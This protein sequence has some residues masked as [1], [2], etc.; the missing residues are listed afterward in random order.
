MKDYKKE[1]KKHKFIVFCEDH[2][3]PLGV[4]RSLGE[5]DIRP[6]VILI[7]NG[8][9][10]KLI[11]K[12]KYPLVIH[13]VNTKEDGLEILI[14]N[15][16]KNNG[17]KPFVYSCSD[18]VC[19][20]IDK[21]YDI[22]KND[23]FVFHGREQ[24]IVSQ[25][26][27]KYAINDIAVKYG[28]S[29]LENEVLSKGEIPRKIEYPVLTKALTSTIYAWKDEMHICNNAEELMNAYKQIRSDK[30]LV[31][32]FINKKNEFCVDGFCFNDGKDV[33]IPYYS[34]YKRFTDLSY[35]AYMEFKPFDDKVIYD[36]IC[37]ILKEIGF[38]GIF[39]V[40]FLIDNDDNKWFLE[41]NFRNSTWSYAYTYGG[42]NMP[43][44]W[45]MGTLFGKIDID[46]IC[47][48]KNFTAIAEYEDYEMA[49]KY[50]TMTLD[51]W[52]KEFKLADVHYFYNEQDKKPF[53]INRF[54]IKKRIKKI[55]GKK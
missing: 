33:I 50:G 43:Y 1:L 42:Y 21:H 40:E 24:G 46:E 45:A 14:S 22:L 31:Q 29:V 36:Q 16:G 34:S 4:V 20:L 3:N 18:N 35:G 9:T 54:I 39:E 23:F 53:S 37:S 17:I 41:I 55:F 49:V 51:E 28:C 15:Y 8:K 10:P 2:Y 44:L 52:I 30:V 13:K 5:A 27:N 12:S 11:V 32:K 19:Q 6:I 48:K 25:Y 38:N 7:T 26:L 47:P